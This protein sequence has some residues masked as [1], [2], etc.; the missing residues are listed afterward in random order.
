MMDEL[1]LKIFSDQNLREFK[2]NS[3]KSSNDND[4]HIALTCKLNI[5]DHLDVTF[6]K[7]ND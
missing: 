5:A 2:N 3:R 4:L 6:R 1:F 7:P